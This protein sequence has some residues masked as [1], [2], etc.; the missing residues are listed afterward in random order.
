MREDAALRRQACVEREQS[1]YEDLR[2]KWTRLT[3]A[4]RE[5]VKGDQVRNYCE[6]VANQ[7]AAHLIAIEEAKKPVQVSRLQR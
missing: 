3:D 5:R 7:I 2:D 4:Q 1:S 6:T